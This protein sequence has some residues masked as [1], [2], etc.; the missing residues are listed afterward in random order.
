VKHASEDCCRQLKEVNVGQAILALFGSKDH[1]DHLLRF[2]NS[3]RWLQVTKYL[4][5]QV[6][7]VGFAGYLCDTRSI[8]Y[9]CIARTRDIKGVDLLNFISLGS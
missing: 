5:V 7:Q 2:S 8:T 1:S 4:C 6:L 9:R 3:A